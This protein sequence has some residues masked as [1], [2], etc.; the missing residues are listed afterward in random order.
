MSWRRL[1]DLPFA[2]GGAACHGRIRTVPE[3]FLVDEELGFSPDGEGEHV[4]I[5]VRKRNQ[6]TDWVSHQLAT[7]A[8]VPQRDVSY[9]GL[10]DRNAVTTQWFSI[11]LANKQEPDWHAL[12]SPEMTVLEHHR[13]LRKLRRGVLQGNRFTLKIRELEGDTDRLREVLNK[14]QTGGFPNYFGDQRFGRDYFNISQ[15]ER[16]FSGKLKKLNRHKRGLYLSAIRSQL[17]NEVLGK[18]IEQDR[19]NHLVNGELAMLDGSRS[20]FTV[21]SV[22]NELEQRLSIQDIH[23]T[24]PLVGRGRSSVEGEIAGLEK[25]IIEAYPDWLEG[26][27]K[28]GLQAERRA[29]RARAADLD[30]SLDENENVLTLNFQLSPGTYATMLIR[31]LINQ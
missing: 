9:A 27:E 11:R 14:I 23:P 19:W 2:F 16:L 31:E 21:E 24:G 28:Y 4:L 29:L 26:L 18:R 15:A 17:F 1:E 7:L 13:H 20:W 10:K 5:H 12:S 8:G 3:D 25:Q 22:D 30:W 6:N